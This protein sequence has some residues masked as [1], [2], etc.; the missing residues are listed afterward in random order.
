MSTFV[1]FPNRNI[2][3]SYLQEI[4]IVAPIGISYHPLFSKNLEL[5]L[6]GCAGYLLYKEHSFYTAET[7]GYSIQSTERI[8]HLNPFQYGIRG[9]IN[10]THTHIN[11]TFGCMYSITG[12]YYFSGLFKPVNKT[13][14]TNFSIMLGIGFFMHR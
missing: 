4:F 8:H 13:P 7:N 2:R 10:L 6:G 11:H 14:T 9:K 1:D 5:E 3:Y 12:N